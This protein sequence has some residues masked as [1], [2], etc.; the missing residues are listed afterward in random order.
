MKESQGDHLLSI[1]FHQLQIKNQQYNLKIKELN[2]ELFG[3]KSTTVRTVQILNA[4]KRELAELI[5]SSTQLKKD[6]VDKHNSISRLKA[7]LEGVE[8]EVKAER[9]KNRKFRMQQSNPDIPHVIDYVRQKSEVYE[10][11]AEA[12]N[13]A[14]KVDIA[15]LAAA[16]TT[17]LRSKTKQQRAAHMTALRHALR[18]GGSLS[19]M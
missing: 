11:E 14:R 10:L 19:H 1:D 15:T 9:A 4:K 2:N 8:E 5:E 18:A 17:T 6:I 12:R 7:D 16:R 13:W 3:V